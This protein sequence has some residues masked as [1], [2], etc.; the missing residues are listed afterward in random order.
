M[1]YPALYLVLLIIPLSACQQQ[2]TSAPAPQPQP[3]NHL[4]G[5]PGGSPVILSYTRFLRTLDTLD[6]STSQVARNEFDR[7]FALQPAEIC[8]TGFMLFWA[9]QNSL[10][11]DDSIAGRFISPVALERL[12]SLTHRYGKPDGQERAAQQ[13]L[14]ENSFI[15]TFEEGGSAGFIIPAWQPIV[16]HFN[17]YVSGPMKESFRM[18]L[19]DEK[20]PYMGDDA[21]TIGPRDL[22]DR[23]LAWE[24][25]LSRYP[26]H[27]YDSAAGSNYNGM[28]RAIVDFS[29][30]PP[31]NGD[32]SVLIEPYYDTVFR[33]IRDSFPRSRTNART[34]RWYQ[35]ILSK[36]SAT[37]RGIRDS[38]AF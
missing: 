33:L 30:D 17:R 13:K 11:R 7:L 38:L 23:T 32:S 3:R 28:I 14:W 2:K 8:D 18:E 10:N 5:Y 4:R 6:L 12:A 37:M 19:L 27:I 15:A 16:Q 35:A 22:V 34:D 9:Y 26:H 20:E 1:R 29:Y 24:H 31:R 36:D 21:V 25:F